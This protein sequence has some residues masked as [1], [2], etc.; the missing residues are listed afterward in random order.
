[1]GKKGIHIINYELNLKSKTY[2]VV[3][4]AEPYVPPKASEPIC[5]TYTDHYVY[6]FSKPPPPP[7]VK[8]GV[9]VS[10]LPFKSKAEKH[11]FLLLAGN[12]GLENAFNSLCR[13]KV[14]SL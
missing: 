5:I 4:F 13:R 14:R 1:M 9:Q 6:D 8:F 10:K 12:I 3:G 7:S 2:F 11:N